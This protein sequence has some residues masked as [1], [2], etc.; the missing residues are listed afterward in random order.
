MAIIDR[1]FIGEECG[2]QQIVLLE[3]C[4]VMTIKCIG[5]ILTDGVTMLIML[6]DWTNA[7]QIHLQLLRIAIDLR[8][9]EKYG[10]GKTSHLLI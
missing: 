2:D 10:D 9:K 7:I 4:G 5:K 6:N 3:K 1:Q 8:E